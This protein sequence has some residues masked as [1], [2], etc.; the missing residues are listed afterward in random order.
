[1]LKNSKRR[2]SVCSCMSHWLNTPYFFSWMNLVV[3]I[4]FSKVTQTDYLKKISFQQV[5]SKFFYFFFI[6][7]TPYKA[8]EATVCVR[9]YTSL[10]VSTAEAEATTRTGRQHT[11]THTHTHTQPPT[12]PFITSKHDMKS[13]LVREQVD[14]STVLSTKTKYIQGHSTKLL[15]PEGT[16]V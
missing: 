13:L 9:G 15:L 10:L 6:Q 4:N 12:Q 5:W 16:M 14:D 11:H 7:I 1:M 2:H 3:H 8:S